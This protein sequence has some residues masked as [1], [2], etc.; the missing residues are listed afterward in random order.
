MINTIVFSLIQNPFVNEAMAAEKEKK[1]SSV[2]NALALT[3]SALGIYGKYLGDKR[4]MVQQQMMAANNQ[5][6][7][8]QMSPACRKPDGTACYTTPGKLFPECTLPASISNMPQNIC[9]NPTPEVNQ[10]SNMMTYEAIANGWINYY[11]QMSNKASNSAYSVGLA[12][13]EG[14]QK[15]LDSQ[16]IEMSNS[17]Q[18]LQDRLNQDKQVFRDNNKKLLEEMNTAND[19]LFGA[20]GKSANNLNMKTQDFAKYFSQNCQSVI[21]KDGLSSGKEKGFS[22]ILQDLSSTNKAA[23]DFGANRAVIE[24]DIRRE[25]DKISATI[26]ANGV[27]DFLA[28]G[29]IPQSDESAKTFGAIQTQIQKQQAEFNAAKARI[30][31]TLSEV[32]YTAPALDSKFSADS[33]D[34]LAGAN[35]FFKKKYVSDCVTGADKGIAIPVEDILKNIQQKRTNNAGTAANDYRA[36]LRKI[37]DSDAMMDQKMEMMKALE[38]QYPGITITYKDASQSRVTESPY[39]LF[40]KTISKCEQ[41]FV[42]DDQFSSKGSSGVSYQKKV[43][44]ARTALQELK[45]LNDGYASKVSQSIL[46]QVLDCGGA[47][48]KSGS[49][50]EKTIDQSAPGFCISHASQCANEIQGCYAE[51]NNHVQTRKTKMENLA[52]KFNANVQAMVARSNALYEQQK[53]AV[54]NITKLIQSKFPGTNFELPKD[55]FVSMPELKKDAFG[56]E[57]AGDGDLKSF[58]DGKDSMPEKIEK[59]K[60]MFKKQ[61]DTVNKEIGDYIA[62]QE[63]AMNTQ[64]ERWADIKQKCE[65]AINQ[66]S[67]AL[68]EQNKEGMKNQQELNRLVAKY[69]DKYSNLRDNPNGGCDEAKDLAT[70]WEKIVDKGGENYITGS[71]SKIASQ[72]NS[73]CNATNNE[74]LDELDPSC[75][76][77]SGD[78]KKTSYCQEKEKA[79]ARKLKAQGK[80]SNSKKLVAEDLCPSKDTKN[81]DFIKNASAK[82]P[83][84]LR[85]KLE[86][87]TTLDDVMKVLKDEEVEGLDF[88]DKIKQNFAAK[89]D[90]LIC[91][92]IKARATPK[93]VD[94]AHLKELRA[95]FE[96]EKD[97]AEKAIIKK[98]IDALKKD[99]NFNSENAKDIILLDGLLADLNSYGHEEPESRLASLGQQLDEQS[100]CDATNTSMLSKNNDFD[101]LKSFDAGVLG[102]A[103]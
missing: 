69:C 8:S 22:G 68:A 98:Q 39:D 86:G 28:K 41:R 103:R 87:K 54:T 73:A 3:N 42:Q 38:D 20:G 83:K 70:T 51:V 96:A 58:L 77:D 32:G 44:R 16:L 95:D 40:M 36:A 84:E 97:A 57:M 13:L 81:E 10:I 18:R 52:K 21:G 31:K 12:C 93:T 5:R 45:T 33:E 11:D 74:A 56:V 66:S 82:L 35:D 65:G 64:K 46:S 43:E 49:C 92:D 62:K 37:L 55:M 14:K 100:S 72:Y 19:E 1:N 63:S 71:A 48:P 29:Y 101:F 27:D 80:S 79:L 67:Q 17:L 34:F 9:T 50:S 94:E 7:M 60:E 26:K 30:T 75:I 47:A 99:R 61:R 88:F 2:E 4:Q 59:L 85:S 102:T 15:A 76:T 89:S 25:T 6:L 23:S 90:D 78:T 53:A 91:K 24:N